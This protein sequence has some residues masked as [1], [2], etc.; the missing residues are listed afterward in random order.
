MRGL[1]KFL[2]LTVLLA[3]PLSSAFAASAYVHDL[4]GT[5][6]SQQGSGPASPLKMGDTFDA[7]VTLATA[8]NSTAVLKFETA[9]S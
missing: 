1:I 6:T 5:L 8:A 3:L 2:S 4:S 9:R 7:G